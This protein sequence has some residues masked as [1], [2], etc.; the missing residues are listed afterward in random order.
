MSIF[1]TTRCDEPVWLEPWVNM[2]LLCVYVPIMLLG[3]AV[4]WFA[5]RVLGLITGIPE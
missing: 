2:T 3:A 1:S 5:A 4:Q